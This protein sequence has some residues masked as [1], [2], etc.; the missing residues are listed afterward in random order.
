MRLSVT[1]R[2]HS[3]KLQFTAVV[4]VDFINNFIRDN[5]LQLSSNNRRICFLTL[6]SLAQIISQTDTYGCSPF[7][8]AY[9]EDRIRVVL[10]Q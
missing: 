4:T 10:F 1:Q 9:P 6:G 8:N 2:K 5:W 3:Y 7:L